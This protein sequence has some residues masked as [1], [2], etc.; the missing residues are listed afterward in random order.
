[1]TFL[2][3]LEPEDDLQF[4]LVVDAH[5]SADCRFGQSE[6]REGEVG[7]GA[8]VD[9]GVSAEGCD[10][11]EGDLLRYSMNGQVAGQCK[12]HLSLGG[13]HDWETFYAGGGELGVGEFVRIEGAGSDEVVALVLI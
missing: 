1:M 13:N 10:A 8:T 9:G 2:A 12:S 3:S 4:D 6:G 7:L 11:L 5:E